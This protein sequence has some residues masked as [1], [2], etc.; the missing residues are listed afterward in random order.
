MRVGYAEASN[1]V[2]VSIPDRP[3]RRLSQT[4]S[5]P[6]PIGVTRPIPVIATRTRA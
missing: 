2:I 5:I 1:W 3:W 4:A 6:V